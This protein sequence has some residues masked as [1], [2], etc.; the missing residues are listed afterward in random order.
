MTHGRETEPRIE[1][2]MSSAIYRRPLLALLAIPLNSVAT[3]C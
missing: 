3:A 2:K 1:V